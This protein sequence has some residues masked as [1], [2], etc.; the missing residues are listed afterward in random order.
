MNHSIDSLNLLFGASGLQH[1]WGAERMV[2]NAAQCQALEFVKNACRRVGKPPATPGSEAL[3][4]LRVAEGYEDLPT[5]SPL[6]SFNPDLV[7]ADCGD[8]PDSAVASLGP[9]R[10]TRGGGFLTHSNIERDRG[11]AETA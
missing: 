2:P 3:E 5:S 9:G 11:R 7:I 8:E 6:G 4:E 10:A 1:S